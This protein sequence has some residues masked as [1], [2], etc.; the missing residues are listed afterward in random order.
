MCFS[1]RNPDD[2]RLC[3]FLHVCE[4]VFVIVCPYSSLFVTARVCV[5]QVY[6]GEKGMCVCVWVGGGADQRNRYV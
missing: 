1:E 4:R 6:A 3:V 2:V 5:L